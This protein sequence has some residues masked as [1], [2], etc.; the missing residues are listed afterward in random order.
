MVGLGV[1][2]FICRR[3]ESRQFSV[4]CLSSFTWPTWFLYREVYVKYVCYEL[5]LNF[6]YLNW[7]WNVVV[8]CSRSCFLLSHSCFFTFLHRV[9]SVFCFSIL[10]SILSSLFIVFL[11]VFRLFFLSYHCFFFLSLKI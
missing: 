6:I 4:A 7:C 10:F 11:F 1:I 3:W 9:S 5:D 2:T 8:N